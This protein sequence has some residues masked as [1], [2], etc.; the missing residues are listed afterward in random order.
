M[1]QEDIA[2]QWLKK[3]QDEEEYDDDYEYELLKDK[4]V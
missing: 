4:G 1:E 3:C 2:G